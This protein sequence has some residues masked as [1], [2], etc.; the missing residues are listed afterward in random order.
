[1]SK[2][3]LCLYDA[4]E[5][6]EIMRKMEVLKT[7]DAEINYVEDEQLI[8]NI[9]AITNRMHYLESNGVDSAPISKNL[10]ANCSDVN[11][12]VVHCATINKQV[13]EKCKQLEIIAVLRGGLDNVDID[14]V[15]KRKITLIHAPWRS[16]N[17]VADFTIGMMIAENK[18]ISRSFH[19]LKEGKWSKN[20]VNQG[21]I[22]DL[23]KC[24][25]GLAGFGNI[26]KRVAKRLEGFGCEILVYD[27]FFDEDYITS[28]NYK[29]VNKNDLLKKSDFISLHLR[30]TMETMNFIDE[31]ALDQ[32]KKEAY[33]INTSRSGIVKTEALIKALKHKKIGG[34]A[35]D[36]F[37]KEPIAID[38]PLLELDNV[39]LTPHIAGFSA[40]T[41]IN[42]V[43]ICRD[44]LIRYF[45][46]QDLL[47]EYKKIGE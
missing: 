3:I 32:M 41:V 39:T 47:N 22:R 24:T 31:E 37:D 9:E 2:K 36:V 8:D 28:F 16:A 23:N 43:E 13:L 38:S 5:P 6:Y 1:M 21:Y 35:L 20:F 18:N 12:L 17:A 29:K 30:Q 42:S 25:I 27:P 34:A 4:N 33:L 19:N 44:D 26:G 10:L 15:D 46:N 45:E 14:E 40:D 11:I 7:Y